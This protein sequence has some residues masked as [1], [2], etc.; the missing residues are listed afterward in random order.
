MSI[1]TTPSTVATGAL[2][3][4]PFESLIGGPLKAC[5]EAQAMA[6]QTTWKFIQEVGLNPVDESG[7]RSATQVVFQYQ[8][9]GRMTNLVVPLLAIVPIPYIAIDTISIDFKANI[10]ASASSVSEQTESSTVGIE[11][12]AG[13]GGAAP[14][15]AGGHFGGSASFKANY[16]SKKDSKA[17]QESKY[18][19]EYTM[20]V[21]VHASQADMPAGLVTVL[22]MLQQAI[23]EAQPGG[24]FEVSPTRAALD[25]K[26][27][28]SS[29]EVLAT[30]TDERGL[31]AKDAEVTFSVD[32]AQG[33]FKVEAVKG[34]LVSKWEQ[35]RIKVKTDSNGQA[36][37][38]M[39]LGEA[40]QLKPAVKLKVESALG[41]ESHS[42]EALLQIV[43][44]A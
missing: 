41:S 21:H 29:Q 5:I 27:P 32:A 37:I 2:Q 40:A 9:G 25:A 10:S 18:S 43:N 34:T 31:L 35:G 38:R 33:G 11:A 39:T 15:G 20:D 26:A 1:D 22:G 14:I 12:G 8:K 44:V 7:N 23:A 3:A 36:A 30:L 16:S 19:V 42:Q 6:A 4:L 28:G 17:T 24:K 13:G